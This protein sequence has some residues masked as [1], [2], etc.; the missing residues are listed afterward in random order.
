MEIPIKHY[1]VALTLL[2]SVVANSQSI[3]SFEGL[4]SL[5]HQGMPNN[6]GMGEVGIGTP[7]AF[8]I[9]TQNPANLLYNRFSSFQVGIELD[10]RIFEGE[11]VTGEDFNGSLRFI[12]YAFPI[13]PGK[14]VSSFGVLPYSTVRYN[15]FSEG[16]V[17]G[18]DGEVE[19]V[20]DNRGSG[21]L[22]S[23]YWS[24]G[25]AI[26]KSLY[27]GIRSNFTFGSINRQTKS[28]IL[29]EDIQI[30]NTTLEETSAYSDLNVQLGL[31]YRKNL[32][33]SR[34]LYFGMTYSPESVISGTETLE[35]NRLTTSDAELETLSLGESGIQESFPTSIGFGVSYKRANLFTIGVDYEFQDWSSQRASFQNL[36]KLSVGAEWIPDY[37]NINSGLKRARYRFGFNILQLPYVV[38][39]Q[40]LRDFGINFGASLPVNVVSSLDLG[41]KWGRLGEISE[42]SIR[43]PIL[44]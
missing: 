13:K 30:N 4:G 11:D 43:K 31:S 28:I 36:T 3:Y 39:D 25:W 22:T 5:E 40:S 44:K 42:N 27:F 15:S 34:F 10:R 17:E 1:L 16:V 32:S 19:R 37:D 14:W 6:F 41:F 23:L 35:L 8:N 12:G 38:N 7:S 9:N 33:D 29:G 26:Y 20:I 18:T 2:L 24:N 21:G